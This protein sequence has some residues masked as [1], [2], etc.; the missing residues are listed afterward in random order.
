MRPTSRS[1]TYVGPPW[2]SKLVFPQ[3]AARRRVTSP[4]PFDFFIALPS[5][6]PFHSSQV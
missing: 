1:H 3:L 4:P 6:S 5:P 2:L